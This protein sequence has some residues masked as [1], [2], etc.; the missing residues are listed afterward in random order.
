MQAQ[1]HYYEIAS[2]A[3]A[4]YNIS[5]ELS[6]QIRDLRL[7]R[8]LTQKQ[9]GEMAGVSHA[10]VSQV[11]RGIRNL[12]NHL[13]QRFAAALDVEP[14]QLLAAQESAYAHLDGLMQKLSSEDRARVEA[15]AAALY[16]SHKDTEQTG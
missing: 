11:E 10:H 4:G 7:A 5:M 13:I 16:Q 2:P 15:F 8:G 14:A 12:N 9:L 3:A 6:I 1:L